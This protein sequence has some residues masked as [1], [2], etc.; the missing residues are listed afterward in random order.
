[1][2][3]LVV[4]INKHFVLKENLIRPVA[5]QDEVLVKVKS[6]SVNPFDAE[7]A[8]GRFDAYFAEYGVTKEV[9]SGLEF[10]G[11]VE[12][13]GHKFKRGDKVFGY[14]NMITGWKSHAEYIAI[15][16][17][18]MAL[19]PINLTFSQAAA[20]PLGTLTTLVALQDVG[21]INAGMKLLINGAAGGLGI[22][23]IQIAKLL[24]AHVTAIAGSSQTEFL[25]SYGAD[26]VY[27]YN[28]VSINDINDTFDVILDLTN[29]LN[30]KD[31]K[32]HLAPNGI[33]I[34]AEPN[35]KNGGELEDKQVGYL[36]VMQGDFEKLTVIANWVSEGKLK[37]VIDR[38]FSFTDY[39]Q[40]MARVK[41]KGRRGR[42]I[43]SW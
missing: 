19:M 5:E 21:Q 32:K 18:Q 15:N 29:M 33:F 37:A 36:M 38:E 39:Q 3:G 8:E 25:Q 35:Q 41:E 24:G 34:P 43:M 11:I 9:Q 10:S 2:K 14:V 22:Q 28:Q 4:D 6:A 1:M 23:G 20:I 30:L 40:A 16:E 42:I 13:D 17:N 31:M 7:S 26:K 27:D 12:S